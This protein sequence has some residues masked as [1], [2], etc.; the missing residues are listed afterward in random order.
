MKN[1]KLFVNVFCIVMACV[2]CFGLMHPI[3]ANAGA[4]EDYAAAQEK[5][6]Q[7]NR[8]ISSLKD[9][10][11][12]QEKELSSAKTQSDLVKK[13]INILNSD[14]K[15]ANENLLAKQEELEK[16]KEDI[17]ATDELFKERLK[18]MYIMRS[19]GT[20]STILAVDSFSQLLTAADTLQRIS[21]ADTDLL[22]ELNEQ[23]KVIEQEEVA[24]QQ[25][26]ND[27]VE[28]QG[29][30]ETKQN[31]LA[32]L[33]K[34]LDSQLSD[35]EAQQAAARETQREV[36]A[37]YLAAKEAV[38]KEFQS[39]GETFVGGEWIWPVPS[40]GYISSGYGA[41]T[42]YGV[43]DWHTGIDISTGWV[44]GKW[45]SINN[46]PIVAS[47]SG[48]VTKATYGRTGYGNYVII[49]HGG[50]NFTLYGHCSSLAVGVGDYVTQ[51]QTIAYVGSTGNSTGPHLHFEIRLN[52]SCVDPA[53][54]IAGT[55]PK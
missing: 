17:Q 8:T 22:K 43:Y 42:L 49:D 44:E 6:D 26:L 45:P 29:T 55:R 13:Q 5:L 31:E 25:R 52:G 50:N 54:Y 12:K 27:L 40:N 32:A 9:T 51:G 11:K 24:I 16:K 47:N 23:K 48:K 20:L 30:L 4:R 46:K 7:I 2:M 18:A 3:V 14:I 28:K 10:K 37:E 1:K 21:I 15:T 35:T 33:L 53:P 38:E 34:K 41:R 39:S 36:Y 19:G